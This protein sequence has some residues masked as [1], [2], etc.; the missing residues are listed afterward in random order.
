MSEDCFQMGDQKKK[1]KLK[2]DQ[3]DQTFLLFTGATASNKNL[4]KMLE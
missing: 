2:L 3:D 1:L 4:I